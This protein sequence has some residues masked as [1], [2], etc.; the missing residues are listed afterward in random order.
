MK[1]TKQCPTC[2][3]TLT[4]SSQSNLGRSIQLNSTCRS[5]RVITKEHKKRLSEAHMGKPKSKQAV[6]KMKKSLKEYWSN[7]SESE[8]N[9]WREMV[10]QTSKE[11]WRDDNYKQQVSDSVKEHWDSLSDDERIS[12][13]I[14]QQDGGAGISKYKMVGEYKVQGNTEKRY[15]QNLI[16]SKK[17]LPLVKTREGIKTPYG[18]TFPDFEYDTHFVEIK[19][20]Y[21]YN[22]MIEDKTQLQKLMWVNKNVKEVKIIVEQ[23]K[24][25]FIQ[26]F[27]NE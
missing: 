26:E 9:D 2:N 15:I 6:S 3:E 27:I 1:Y 16:N 8:M 24:N 11:R 4:Y 25:K 12:R 5:C 7:K 13:F 18:V 20:L 10:S 14:K 17:K 23:Y 19:S 21:T 22:K